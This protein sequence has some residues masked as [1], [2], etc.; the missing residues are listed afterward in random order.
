MFF[1]EAELFV[2]PGSWIEVGFAVF[3][4][5]IELGESVMRTVASSWAET[6]SPSSSVPDA[7]TTS[8]SCAALPLT[9]PA[10]EQSPCPG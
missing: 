7:V 10:N 3:V 4:T 5:T 9:W 1:T 6:G 2:P 8:V